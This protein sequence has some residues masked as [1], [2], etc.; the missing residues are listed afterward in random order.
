MPWLIGIDEAGYGPNLG[1]FVMSSVACRVP[2]DLLNADLWSVL[3]PAVRRP[4]E[5]HDGRL[6]IEDSKLVY[7]PSRGLLDLEMGV[8]ATL[9]PAP[10]LLGDH[11]SAE[12][13]AELT[14]EAWFAP[15]APLPLEADPATVAAAATRFVDASAGAGISWGP[16]NQV[17][18]CPARFNRLLDAWDTKGAVLGH[19]LAQLLSACRAL[20]SEEPLHFVIDKHGGRNTYS[21]M[22]Q[23]AFPDG[24]VAAREEGMARSVYEVQGLGREVR[25]TF[26]PRADA[27]YL[28]VALASMASKYLREV[29]MRHF[30]H[31]WRSHVPGLKPTAG[32]PGDAGRFFAAIEPT[33]E[34][35]GLVPDQV[36]RRK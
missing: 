7:S 15:A 33:L 23:A 21:A 34:R 31:Y 24:F 29:L 9:A 10:T 1:P 12:A 30:N 3:R 32:Y 36:W 35:L 26:Q 5:P 28:G 25:L 4:G 19:A 16:A 20:P 6:L 22:L 17:V 8:L 11:L 2:P 13:L 18:V 14:G 27:T